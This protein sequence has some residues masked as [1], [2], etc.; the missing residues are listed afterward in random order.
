MQVT[1]HGPKKRLRENSNE[2]LTLD[3][4]V[5]NTASTPKKLSHSIE[6]ILKK[7]SR[8]E[9]FNTGCCHSMCTSSVTGEV[10]TTQRS[11][12]YTL[13]SAILT[14]SPKTTYCSGQS[15]ERGGPGRRQNP[16]GEE[17]LPSSS[18]AEEEKKDLDNL[19]SRS[20]GKGRSGPSSLQV[21]WRRKIR[22]IF[23]PGQVEKENP[24]QLHSRSGG[25]GR[26]GPASLQVRRRRKTRTSFTPGQEEKEDPDQLHSRSG[27]EGRS[28]PASLQVRRRRKT[29]TSFTPGQEEKEDPDQLHSRSGGEG[30]SGPASL[31]V[32]RRRK[33]RT[34]FTPGQVEELEKVFLE[35]HYPDVH[36]RDTLASHLKLTEG[37]VQIWF[38][39]RRAKWR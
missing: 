35:T 22:T 13:E 31:Q 27:G 15:R 20:G 10:T 5:D 21:R 29:R 3:R 2:L 32:R 38:Q 16:V 17:Q 12:D 34:S 28:G 25:E 1:V 18:C 24:D 30:R 39:N 23:T 37:R 11:Q 6:E 19:H 26:S 7:P 8:K 4:G 14:A 9:L 33:T 36:I